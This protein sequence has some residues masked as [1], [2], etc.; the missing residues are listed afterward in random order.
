MTTPPPKVLDYLKSL[1]SSSQRW[2]VSTPQVSIP[3]F[4]NET[5]KLDKNCALILKNHF[6]P[7]PV[8]VE[9]KY[10]PQV[11]VAEKYFMNVHETPSKNE[12]KTSIYKKFEPVELPEIDETSGKKLIKQLS[13]ENIAS[14]YTPIQL[15]STEVKLDVIKEIIF[16]DVPII[17]TSKYEKSQPP[18]FPKWQDENINL[19]DLIPEQ[20]KTKPPVI[21]PKYE[22]IHHEYQKPSFMIPLN[23]IITPKMELKINHPKWD[24]EQDTPQTYNLHELNHML[25]NLDTNFKSRKYMIQSITSFNPVQKTTSQILFG[26][27]Q[28]SFNLKKWYL[29]RYQLSIEMEWKPFTT[30]LEDIQSIF[31]FEEIVSVFEPSPKQKSGLSK[32]EQLDLILEH[33]IISVGGEVSFD[34]PL[35]TI[36]LPSNSEKST[37]TP[38]S[39]DSSTKLA[40]NR[41]VLA[42]VPKVVEKPTESLQSCQETPKLTNSGP[43]KTLQKTES[44]FKK[45]NNKQIIVEAS[46]FNGVVNTSNDGQ[47]FVFP[48][49]IKR[50]DPLTDIT[51]KVKP[52]IEQPNKSQVPTKKRDLSTKALKNSES[53]LTIAEPALPTKDVDLPKNVP[54]K[55]TKTPHEQSVD[56]PHLTNQATYHNDTDDLDQLVAKKKRKLNNQPIIPN[57]LSFVSFLAP[58]Q[59]PQPKSSIPPPPEP[60]ETTFLT[61][62]TKEYQF[63]T[64][65]YI[66]INQ[67]LWDKQYSFVNA[68]KSKVN[69]IDCQFVH[70][71][72]LVVNLKTGIYI[73]KINSLIQINLKNEFLIMEELIK[74]KQHFHKLYVIAIGNES[75]LKNGG[76]N[77]QKFLLV[78]ASL[79]IKL[80]FISKDDL[81]LWCL[82]I[83]EFEK[84]YQP[85]KLIDVEDLN[86]NLLCEMG[87]NNFQANELLTKYNLKQFINLV[88]NNKSNLLT[89]IICIDLLN[90][91]KYILIEELK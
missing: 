4:N 86:C 47:S 89:E 54:R 34:A 30:K 84:P 41:G 70:D 27:F 59:P 29:K 7:K 20:I 62:S 82:E 81:E 32:I 51:N 56:L 74:M 9:L 39:C 91:L 55:S 85:T 8:K 10:L 77:L 11:I 78:C 53:S 28:K 48:I 76:D 83:I 40:K 16:A 68:I 71:V 88:V 50:R 49:N 79:N 15:P 18:K 24:I 1:K 57:E 65:Q 23:Q 61:D 63:E 31:L 43:F 44:S 64:N 67:K 45:P 87:L 75:T 80:L 66:L 69:L 13:E 17:L 72:D 19:F 21:I 58:Q 22:L 42:E 52:S 35:S 90:K 6:K 5:I 33:P 73:T 38:K 2:D 12:S 37:E 36:K 14:T 25:F 26:Y 46:T 60:Q 3:K